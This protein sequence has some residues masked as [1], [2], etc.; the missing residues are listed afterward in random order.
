MKT[1]FFLLILLTF[2]FLSSC[3]DDKKDEPNNPVEP[4]NRTWTTINRDTPFR[5]QP[6]LAYYEQL[7]SCPMWPSKVIDDRGLTGEVWEDYSYWEEHKA[8]A[9]TTE[10]L[11]AMCDVPND[12]LFAMST[13]NLALT[14]LGHPYTAIYIAYNS[15]Y[16][17]PFFLL[18]ANCYSELIQRLTG[19][20]ELLNLY[21]KL[22]YTAEGSYFELNALSIFL[23]TAVDFNALNKEELAR[24]ST[25]IFNK[26]DNIVAID[27]SSSMYSG[28]ARFHYLLGAFIAYHYDKQLSDEDVELLYDF[29]GFQGMPGVDP[30]TGKTFTTEDV[31][32][33]TLV[34]SQSLERMEW[35]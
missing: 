2:V 13:Q 18:Q 15:I 17:S 34:I 4:V 30:A 8:E 31:S 33:S 7:H 24:L 21:C 10:E 1:N 19:A 26:I 25:E 20:Q 3:G 23:M 28:K 35:N 6:L 29:T 16:Q 32:R 12:K 9:Q 14:C 5:E 27:E 22:K 11:L